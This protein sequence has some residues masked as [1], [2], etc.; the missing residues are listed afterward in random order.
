MITR[1]RRIAFPILAVVL[2]LVVASTLSETLSPVLFALLLAVV[3]NPLVDFAARLRMPRV[4]TVALL[5]LGLTLL[6]VFS[7]HGVWQQF[8]DLAITLSGE[9][10]QDLDGD[11]LIELRIGPEGESEFVDLNGNG[12][13][14][15]GAL[16]ELEAWVNSEITRRADG[17]YGDLLDEART[18][19]LEGLATLARPAGDMIADLLEQGA[20]WA[21]GMMELVTLVVLIPFYLFFFLVEFPAM[22]RRLKQLVPRRHQSQVERVAHDIRHELVT[23]LRGRLLCGF[24]KALFLWAGMAFLGVPFALVIALVTGLL[25]LIPFFGFLVGVIPAAV[26]ALTM[27]GGGTDSVLW[28]LVVFG[29]G[30]AL[31]G[32]ILFPLILG[33]ETG[34]HPV[35]LVV[36]LLAGG[37]LMGTLGVIVAIPLALIGK[38]LWRELGRPLYLEWA[39]PPEEAAHDATS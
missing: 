28:V 30:E 7:A 35:L 31:E 21:G 37:S 19:T 39:D 2:V 23:F 22:R 1:L 32:A 38:V 17:W 4:A 24:V 3:L 9:P 16:L 10:F 20:A 29:T 11:A 34:L 36:L 15:G 18:T 27:P 5:Y 26:L 8:Q 14:D 12:V 33:R 13:Y 6:L 25:S